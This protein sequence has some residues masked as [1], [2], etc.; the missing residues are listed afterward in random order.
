MPVSLLP[1]SKFFHR[2]PQT[3]ADT[4]DGGNYQ[5]EAVIAGHKPPLLGCTEV[6]GWIPSSS[7]QGSFRFKIPEKIMLQIG[8]STAMAL[9]MI[10]NDG[11][12]VTSWVTWAECVFFCVSEQRFSWGPE[13]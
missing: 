6:I 2:L 7:T 9:P 10:V 8:V 1:A 4:L 13:V 3:R 12:P 11:K 5:A